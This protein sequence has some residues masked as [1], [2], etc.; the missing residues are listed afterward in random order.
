[1]LVQ[2]A[3]TSQSILGLSPISQSAVSLKIFPPVLFRRSLSSCGILPV[4]FV[5]K[6]SAMKEVIVKRGRDSRCN[7]QA[8]HSQP[9]DYHQYH[10]LQ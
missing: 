1:M 8:H 5:Y 4:K 3:G 7:I 2:H 10:N 9:W 6:K